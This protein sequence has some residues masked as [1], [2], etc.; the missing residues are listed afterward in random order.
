MPRSTPTPALPDDPAAACAQL[1]AT[2]TETV[3][4][5]AE[6]YRVSGLDEH[7]EATARP[8]VQLALLALAPTTKVEAGKLGWTAGV[9]VRACLARGTDRTVTGVWASDHVEHTLTAKLGVGAAS[10]ASLASVLRRASRTLVP[11]GQPPQPA[12][13]PRW[14]NLA[15]YDTDEFA[16]LVE[17]VTT[18]AAPLWRARGTLLVALSAGAGL[19]NADLALLGPDDITATG[20][21]LLVSLRGTDRDR[22]VPVR[23]EFEQ[24]AAAAHAALTAEAAADPRVDAERLFP[25]KD[26][27]S[28]CFG[29]LAWPTGLARPTT[30]R[31]RATWSALTLSS[32]CGLPAYLRAAHITS[33]DSWYAC[34]P[35]LPD[36]PFDAYCAQVRGSTDPFVPDA[37]V[38]DGQ[39][40]L[41]PA[42]PLRDDATTSPRRTGRSGR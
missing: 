16:A 39:P 22:M 30:H 42:I 25:G 34:V 7:D 20:H 10:R 27:A 8:L 1:A 19:T 12:K 13:H 33:I 17:A 3:R 23:H 32:G 21:G 2:R 40:W 14:A 37:R 28:R 4:S 36:L 6:K 38:L 29:K 24:L 15:P 5:Y 26:A 31:L 9:H 11:A 41:A 35:L 18:V